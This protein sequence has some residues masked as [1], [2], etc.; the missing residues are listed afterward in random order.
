MEPFSSAEI[1]DNPYEVD[2]GK[3]SRSTGFVEVVHAVPY[4]FKDRGE[5]GNTDTSSDKK[6]R[7]VLCK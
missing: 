5:W 6:D 1:T 2:F 4:G 7:F 3:A